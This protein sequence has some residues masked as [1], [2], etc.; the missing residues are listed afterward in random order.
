MLKEGFL[1]GGATAAN[2]CEGAY[3]ED[4]KGLSTQD[5]IPFIE[6]NQRENTFQI[7]GLTTQQYEA[8]KR[9]VQGNYPKRRG[10][11]FYH[12]YKEDI[13]L[14]AEMGFQC[15]R[16]SISWPRIFPN[17]DDEQPNEKGLAFYDAV[18]DECLKYGIEPLVTLSHFEMPVALVDK[19]NGWFDRRM[20]TVFEHYTQIVFQRYQKKVKY[21]LTF[22]EI[23]AVQFV[24][25]T[26]A[27]ILIDRCDCSKEQAIYQTLHHMFIASSLAV[28]QCHE[29]IPDAKIGCMIARRLYYPE[30]SNPAKV[31]L[32]QWENSYS[33]FCSDVQARGYYPSYMKS[34]FKKHD[35]HI[36]M[37]RGDEEL[38]KQYTVDFISFSYYHSLIPVDHDT[39]KEDI[40]AGNVLGGKKNPFI[41]INDWGW[42]IDPIGLKIALHELYERYEKPLF[43]VENGLGA[44]DQVDMDGMIKDDGRINYLRAHI[45]QMIE[46]VEEGVDLMGYTCWGPIDI[47]SASTSEMKKRYGFIY[48]DLD[49]YGKGS[50]KRRKKKSFDWYKQVIA[51]NGQDL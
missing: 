41:H 20:I 17:G 35:I 16:M 26:A 38:L 25:Y 34:Y 51:S 19:Y 49:D 47:V 48:V 21:W 9:D 30:N 43:I 15:Y 23:N 46:A 24:P 29:I 18:F 44:K 37:Q 36:P 8:A 22:N 31:R 13:A 6:E 5:L 3:L 7:M 50:G 28:K 1:W 12:H 2:Q 33:L 32:A 11:D 14:F 40:T 42:G 27:G 10:I 45:T 39:K 4:G